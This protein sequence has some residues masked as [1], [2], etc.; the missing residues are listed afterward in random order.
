VGGPEV[1]VNNL[2]TAGPGI[3]N[4]DGGVNRAGRR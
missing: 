1:G 4:Q 2:G 3:A